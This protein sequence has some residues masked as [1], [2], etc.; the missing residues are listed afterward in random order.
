MTPTAGS[1]NPSKAQ[2]DRRPDFFAGF[3]LAAEILSTVP[4]ST[5]RSR[6]PCPGYDVATLVSHLVGAANPSVSRSSEA[7]SSAQSL[8]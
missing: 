1:T 6:T 8:S 5:L 2:T 3:D 4:A 7:P